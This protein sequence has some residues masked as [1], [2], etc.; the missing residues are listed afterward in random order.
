[1]EHPKRF[2]QT[3]RGKLI[4][5][6]GLVLC[7]S[8]LTWIVNRSAFDRIN[9]VVEDLT[10][11]NHR[12]EA[13]NDLQMEL[14][15]LN[16]F[17]RAEAL[18]N[19][20]NPSEEYGIRVGQISERLKQL[21]DSFADNPD[22][23][24]RLVEVDSIFTKR[25]K[26]FEK[27]LKIR[28]N[29]INSGLVDRQF[30]ELA[31]QVD[32]EN[33]KVDTNVV[34]T[35]KQTKTYTYFDPVVKEEVPVKKRRFRRR[36]EEVV[37]E[38]KPYVVVEEKTNVHIDT[39]AVSQ[40]KDSIIEN[41]RLSLDHVESERNTGRKFL[42]KQE[43]ILIKSNEILFNRLVEVIGEVKNEESLYTEL[44]SS[45]SI[46]IARDTISLTKMLTLVFVLVAFVLIGFIIGDVSKFN[47]YR[48]QLEASREEAEFHSQAK[49]RFLSN[50]S[51]EI[52]SPLQTIVGYS[53]L[54]MNEPQTD[55]SKIEVVSKA[56]EHLLQVVNEILDYSRIISSNFKIDEKPF[57]LTEMIDE[58]AGFTAFQC[59][60]KGIRWNFDRNEFE[61]EKS[62]VISD[63]FR[64]KQIL[65][66]ILSNAVKFTEKGSVSLEVQLKE[67]EKNLDVN[68]KILDTGIGM[69]AKDLKV[70][71]QQFEQARN[72]PI[73]SGTGLGLSIVKELVEALKGE[74]NVGSSLGK[75]TVFSLNF[76]FEKAEKAVLPVA[77]DEQEHIEL[78]GVLWVVDDDA[79]I[80][81]LCEQ[82]L[83]QKKLRY[84][85]F[86]DPK[87]LLDATW[88]E[89]V[90]FVYADVRM[91]GMS[92][93]E[94][95]SRLK[96]R[97]HTDVKIVALT[98]QVLPEEKEMF[99]QSGFDGIVLKPFKS[100]EFYAPIREMEK[101]DSEFDFSSLRQMI[102]DENDF[103]E[104]KLQF[105]SDSNADLVAM[106]KALE[107]ENTR[108]LLLLVH[109]LAGRFGQMGSK[110]LA[111][112]LRELEV[113]LKNTAKGIVFYEVKEIIP[114]L[115]K[116]LNNL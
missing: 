11:P 12:L 48:K 69:S 15:R 109:R 102:A 27:Y 62:W 23:V 26:L 84:R 56:S 55:K 94:L 71:F 59:Q 8:L 64:L 80:L 66:N 74:M 81:K 116:A 14:S 53:E 91:P 70:V 2:T 90:K 37:M 49:Q 20:Y 61:A 103:R 110:K 108:D 42:Q 32:K 51:H 58:V 41:I 34:T 54:M 68:F 38:A 114:Q 60:Q 107:E 57:Q 44:S 24:Q 36:K 39:L 3:T 4:L 13:L 95:C 93:I 75:G 73:Q 7:I 85:C 115:E 22:Q 31:D 76:S 29:Y 92:G 30:E 17:Y 19:K 35:E 63:A 10:K 99:L 50:M 113:Q 40:K 5:A 78:D 98:A 18:Q 21:K 52:R 87:E 89:D 105:V 9:T 43:L 96:K 16:D 112:K 101:K 83:K 45:R 46:Q 65:I 111:P 6:F 100:R 106:N 33:L 82:L 79:A 28:Y 86:N 97:G 88:D 1:M 77:A 67:T 72:A 47:R 104:I 25:N